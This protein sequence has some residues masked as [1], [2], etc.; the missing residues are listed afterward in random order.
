MQSSR[1]LSQLVES[2]RYW[3]V[4]RLWARERLEHDEVVA[5]AIA[6][7]VVCDGLMLQSVDARWVM[8]S[9]PN[10]EL[11]GRPFVGFCA[12]PGC[13]MSII[14]ATA[15]EHLL[16]VVHCAEVPSPQK[17]AEEFFVRADFLSWCER[18]GVEHP[19]F[20]CDGEVHTVK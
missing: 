18:S 9:D 7:A 13:P 15:L 14:R 5:R 17:L 19:R 11:A 16:A 12:A 6:R 3:D 1:P 8:G 20:W 4:V 2:Y 10:L